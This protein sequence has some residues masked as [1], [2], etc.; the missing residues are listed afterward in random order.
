MGRLRSCELMTTS[1]R[2]LLAA[3]V[4]S[5]SATLA[6]A[7]SVPPTND[8][9]VQAEPFEVSATRLPASA[10][11]TTQVD[12]LSQRDGNASATNINGEAANFYVATSG[13][14]SF[15]DTFALR[16][17]ANTPIFGDPDVTVYLDDMPLASGFTFPN[18]LVG[19]NSANLYRGPS[20]NTR[21]GRAGTIGVLQF[22]TDSGSGV[23]NELRA[24]YGNYNDRGFEMQGSA[25][26]T[27]GVDLYAAVGYD[28]RD[29]YITN[30]TL[31][32]RID[33]REST[34][35]L[36]KLH[37]AEGANGDWNFLATGQRV[38][39]GV[40]PLV[41]LDGPKY[42][43]QR[44]EEGI[45]H[46]DDYGLSLRGSFDTEIG[47]LSTTT[48]YTDWRL[49]PATNA[50]NF[51]FA[52]LEDNS[53]LHEHAWTEEINL[54]STGHDRWHGSVGLFAL[55]GKTNGAF[56]RGFSGAVFEDSD[57]T[58]DHRSL[59]AFGETDFQ[60]SSALT[61]TAGLRFEGNWKKINR[62]EV[63]PA[64]NNVID[65]SSYSGAALPKLSANYKIDEQTEASLGFTTGYKP[66]GFSSFTGNPALVKFGA[67]R[68]HGVEAAITQTDHKTWS[69]TLRGFAYW[70]DGYQIERSFQ[71]GDQTDDYIVV[72]AP[73]ARSYGTE[74]ELT[75]QLGGGFSAGADFGY[76]NVTL[77][78]F[79]DPYVGTVYNGKRAPYAPLFN[80]SVHLE[81]RNVSGWFARLEEVGNGRV[82][83]TEGED[84]TFSQKSYYLL[85]ARLGYET[86]KYRVMLYGDNLTNREYFA[87]ITPG[88]NHGTPGDPRTYGVEVEWKF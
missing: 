3:G 31:N 7:Q 65:R 27:D 79:V 1:S 88:T 68:L 56:I 83:Y 19:F 30:T 43:V 51:G 53:I 45:T 57:F 10:T 66:G 82:F 40:Q 13:A 22:S 26:G 42:S 15:N 49:G 75:H 85:N 4:C 5:A 64:T 36:V 34:S 11:T 18:D 35:G 87:S 63:V 21:F 62:L 24:H 23:V 32:R 38:R 41:P 39:D 28:A 70:I 76:T 25:R 54:V 6:L 37:F 61:L 8:Q 50:L 84:P 71:T 44:T 9:T 29:G 72:N 20:Q 14:R 73:R 74:V 60:V 17:L 47:K 16:G 80:G 2:I 52:E 46:L 55:D 33:G 67:E 69:A 77:R 78:D 12:L 59:A 81:Y 48:S 86:P 58:T